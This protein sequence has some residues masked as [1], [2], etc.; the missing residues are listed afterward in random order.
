MT[1]TVVIVDDHAAF[2]SAA[3]LLLQSEG[4]EVVG[5]AENG[6]AA[7]EAAAMLKPDLV[8]LDVQLPD[9]DGIEVAKRLVQLPEPPAIVFTST[10]Q[11][12]DYGSR[13]E[14]APVRGFLA[15]DDLSGIRIA[16]LVRDA[17][18]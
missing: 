14:E 2:R 4:F 1:T 17:A 6:A 13:L 3:R 16:R 18:S 5:E 8:L 15:K 7:V 11:A 12:A 9:L 10:R